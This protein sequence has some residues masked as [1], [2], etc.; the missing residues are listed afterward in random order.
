M[1][2]C[3]VRS[4]NGDD[5]P[6][7][8]E[9]K[10]K[11]G[12]QGTLKHQGLVTYVNAGLDTAALKKLVAKKLSIFSYDSDFQWCYRSAVVYENSHESMKRDLAPINE[13][14]EG[15]KFWNQWKGAIEAINMIPHQHLSDLFV[16]S[17]MPRIMVAIVPG[18]NP[19]VN[20]PAPLSEFMYGVA[21]G[22]ETSG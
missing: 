13:G 4:P 19:P 1:F 8:K 12:T 18:N 11:N 5:T 3:D 2:V 17:D 16:S 20:L 10:S 7:L 15:G 6:H 14:S 22:A 9:F 21:P